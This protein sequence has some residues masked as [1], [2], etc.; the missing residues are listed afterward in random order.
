[1][2]KN[3]RRVEAGYLSHPDGSRVAYG[4]L[5][6]SGP[7]IM[8]CGGFNSDMQ[9][10][11]VLALEKACAEAGRQFT[12]FDYRGH[13]ISSGRLE[14]FAITDWLADTELVFKE[15]ALGPVII[16]GSSMGAWIAS[17]MIKKHPQ[18]FRGFVSVAGAPDFTEQL[19]LPQLAEELK[20]RLSAG[21]TVHVPTEYD[22]RGYPIKQRLLDD[23]RNHLVLT[24]KLGVSCPVCLLHG[25][26]DK[27]VPWQHAVKFLEMLDGDHVRLQLIKRGDHRLSEPDQLRLLIEEV[28]AMADA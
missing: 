18:W 17:L 1:M 19:M 16:V 15:L 20:T 28:F 9:G 2:D 23:G 14:D 3:R 24:E 10:N 5:P 12:R 22:D 25:M 21:E 7:G 13:G 11:K 8:F 4:H 27:T 6:G 26:E